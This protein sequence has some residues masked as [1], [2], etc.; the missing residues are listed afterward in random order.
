MSLVEKKST[1]HNELINVAKI[2]L[3]EAKRLGANEAEVSV[4]MQKGFTVS[5]TNGAVETIEYHH[6]KAIDV[7]VYFD[8]RSGS[9]SLSDISETAI[10]AAV[11][12][13][14]HIAKFT[15]PD[16]AAGIAEKNLLAF[17]YPKL[18]LA[19]PWEITVEKAIELACEIE[20]EAL[21]CDKRIMLAEESKVGSMESFH[22]Y[23]NSHDFLGYFPVTHH[24][25]ACV[26]VAKKGDQMQR[27]YSYTLASDPRKLASVKTIAKEAADRTVK[28]LGARSIKTTKAPVIFIPEDARS[29][30]GHFMSAIQG[31]NLYRHA[32]FLLD[33]LGKP[34]FPAF[35]QIREEPHLP[36][37]LGSAPFDDDGVATRQNHFIKDG[38]LTQY[39][40][41]VYSARKLGM[42]TT[43]NS[44]GVHNLIISTSDQSFEQ[45]LKNMG[46][47][48]VVTELMGQGVNLLTGDYSR[49]AA[50]FWVENGEIQFPVHEVTIAGNLKN[51]FTNIVTVGN[52]VDLRGNIRTGSLLIEEMMIAGN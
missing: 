46:R 50:G 27:D 15:D 31:G 19:S 7:T 16:P 47:G 34:I 10:H 2:I 45:L 4:D 38:I 29:I 40:M 43:G 21:A 35:M 30:F 9:A 26:L 49:G 24:E 44:G 41:G 33:M 25:M 37:G 20:R 48:L 18:E 17:D 52:D 8:K 23:G 3:Q 42:E 32:S 6:D 28:R 13:A 51:M 12:A 11:S 22:I 1:D 39:S 14:C 36:H 5:A